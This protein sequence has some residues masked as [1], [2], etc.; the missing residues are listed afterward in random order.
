MD[1]QNGPSKSRQPTDCPQP[2][3]GAAQPD[4][5][6]GPAAAPLDPLL[7]AQSRDWQ[8]GRRRLVEDYLA[9][10]A[11]LAQDAAAFL[12]LVYHEVLLRRRQGE[13]PSLD[14]YMQRFPQLGG[15]LPLLFEVDE[16]LHAGRPSTAVL[17]RQGPA[18]PGAGA[19][20]VVP[21]VP[22][23]E[24]LGELGRGGMGV[25]YRARQARPERVV[26]LK[27]LLAG[28]H[29]G[30]EELAR[31]KAE[32]EA[33]ARLQHP[34]IVQ[35]YEVGEY[36]GHPFFSM[37]L[38]PG[39]SLADRLAGTPLAAR[40]A[41][42]LV[43][44]LARALH[45]AHEAGVI[46][47]DLKPANVLLA[48][49][50][51]P[52]VADFGLAKRLDAA[53]PATLSGHILGTPSYMAPEQAGGR[54]KAVGPAT[55]VYA[56]GAV[57]YECLTG[58]PPFKAATRLDTL[59][60]VQTE[61]PVPPSRLEPKVPRDL[62]T[63]CLKCLQKDRQKRYASAAELADDLGRS[64]RG[65][66][67][68]ARPVGR[69][70]KAAKW[71]RR[72]PAAAGLL[73]VSAVA[74]LALGG[75]AAAGYYNA[76][77]AVARGDAETARRGEEAQ[78]QRA[79][80][81]LYFM[82]IGRAHS[83][84][85]DADV[86]RAR[87]ILDECDPV[88]RGWEW[89]YLHRLSHPELMTL[90]GHTNAVVG[91]AFSP[92]GSR[93]ATASWDGTV[94]LW[95]VNGGQEVLTL[96]V[97]KD[98]V[99]SLAFS[100]D[101]SR[102][103]TASGGYDAQSKQEYGGV[104]MWDVTTGREVPTLNWWAAGRAAAHGLAWSPDGA[105]VA[106]VG[107]YGELKVRD[108]RTGEE[109]LTIQGIDDHGIPVAFSPDGGRLAAAALVRG[110][111]SVWDAR[112]G[113]ED[114]TLKGHA[115]AVNGVAWSPDGSHLATAS[116]DMTVKVW[117]AR[118]GEEVL[119][120]KGHTGIVYCAVFSPD[121]ARL[122]SAS[123]DGTVKIWDAR[124]GQEALLLRG[125]S[126]AVL[127]VAFSP[128][129]SRLASA[130]ADGTAKL[131]DVS[132]RAKA[133]AFRGHTNMIMSMAWSADGKHLASAS[134]DQSVKVWNAQTGE[135]TLTL[136]A[137]TTGRPTVAFSPD[138]RRLATTS[139][140]A[141]KVWDT[142]TKQEM[143]TLK[144]QEFL[145]NAL[146]F[147]P[148]VTR[149]ASGSPEGTVKVWDASTGEE[150]LSL[151][152]HEG[153]VL[154]MAWSPDGM[155]L[156]SAALDGT[157]KIWDTQKGQEAFL[158]RGHSNAVMAV[159]FSA[160]GNRLASAGMDG[161]VKVW[162]TRTGQ[163]MLSLRGHSDTVMD[164]AFSPDGRRL[165]SATMYGTVKL[166]D[167]RSGQE[168]LSLKGGGVCVAWSPD[169]NRLASAAADM[170]VKVWDATPLDEPAAQEDMPGK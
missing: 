96:W 33:A 159:V 139:D 18:G 2:P 8:E 125:H 26:A 145:L 156:A 23:Y 12:D 141:V 128:D 13:A 121:G 4:D 35:I 160:D 99:N 106:S 166:W 48:A 165:A 65:E 158:L 57:L 41:A 71:A 155:R 24:I 138:G 167:V 124:S 21:A 114:L 170:T 94:K 42:E 97:Q 111:V 53:L 101:G 75:L 44:T 131:W 119:T 144:G 136:S 81:L 76:Q 134:M 104:Q 150:R 161:T 28:A 69:L 86:V 15:A 95:E 22:G 78:R 143:V 102:L 133:P 98:R 61:E 93:L 14:E 47:R 113:Q 17:F 120:L 60:L 79:E 64:Q 1:E 43:E 132:S 135:E 130:S 55:D 6:A 49:D 34:H 157:V 83:A 164:L 67:I 146:A 58:R 51:T 147:S 45:A 66:P 39:G 103:A 140:N 27:V 116:G 84:W 25:V 154:G 32:A 9:G 126:H 70:E 74:L 162:D 108:A 153:E 109:T 63:V 118:T 73:A 82:S 129:G 3:H 127:A 50:G 7:D 68:R 123:D 56:L 80:G 36:D 38:C 5:A 87:Q 110:K 148:D 92:D 100:P 11:A 122:A 77:L 105:R 107:R 16:A 169:G 59:L 37:E 20:A 163:E 137:H 112:T 62:E 54:S 142:N 89:Q 91:V 19:G 40:Q 152:G 115:K 31:F 72:H 149:L 117:D 29:A 168:A 10:Q 46:H 85:L 52:K 90:R 88:Q 151:Q 30:E